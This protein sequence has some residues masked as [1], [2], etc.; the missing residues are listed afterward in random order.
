MQISGSCLM[1]EYDTD[2]DLLDLEFY[3]SGSKLY[4]SGIAGHAKLTL[5]HFDDEGNP[6]LKMKILEIPTHNRSKQ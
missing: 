4:E 3:E 6:V 5:P 2:K 1:L